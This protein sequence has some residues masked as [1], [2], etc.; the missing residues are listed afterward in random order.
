MNSEVKNV[1]PGRSELR[2][3]HR[4]AMDVPARLLGHDAIPRPVRIL[5]IS[6]GGIALLASESMLANDTCALAF[7]VELNEEV[8]RINVWARVAYCV[9]CSAGAFRIGVHFRD[10]DSRSKMHIERICDISSAL[11]AD[12]GIFKRS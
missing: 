11:A 3:H 7:D 1:S 2:L 4:R 12:A 5:D 8:R 6:R 10:Y 9:P